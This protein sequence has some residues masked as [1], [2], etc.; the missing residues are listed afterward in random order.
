MLVRVWNDNVHP[1]QQKIGE[2]M[3]KIP[4]GQCVEMDEDEA[5]K[6]LKTYSPIIADYDGRPVATSFKKLRI[7]E[8][9]IR[10]N[11]DRKEARHKAGSYV[12]QA[13]GYVAS[14]KWELNG[15]TQAEHPDQW[16]DPQGAR[17]AIVKETKARKKA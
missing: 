17:E 10:K 6:L 3:Y 5:D 1:F 11:N 15:H 8:E 9:D 12:C 14:N 13:C 7:D 16:E 2:T 4:A